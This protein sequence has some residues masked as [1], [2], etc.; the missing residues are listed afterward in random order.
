VVVLGG[1]SERALP[2]PDELRQLLHQPRTSLVLNLSAMSRRGEGRLR[3]EGAQRGGVRALDH[4][5]AALADPRR[6]RTTSAP[7][8]GPPS[9]TCCRGGAESLC[10]IT[11]AVTDLAPDVRVLPN[12][13]A[14]TELEASRRPCAPP[15]AADGPHAVRRAAGAGEIV[16]RWLGPSPARG[17]PPREAPRAAPAPLC[18]STRRAS[19]R[20]TDLSTSETAGALNLRAANSC[21]SSSWP[22]ASTS[23]RGR[24][25]SSSTITRRGRG[26]KIKDEG[27]ATAL[28]EVEDAAGARRIAPPPPSRDPRALYRVS[29]TASA[30]RDLADFSRD[31]GRRTGAFVS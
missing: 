20:R 29:L 7:P 17:V 6:R 12:V 24:G 5:A 19:C 8:T 30:L 14:A 10:M 31:P 26:R 15:A 16:H 22:R 4:R 18:A 11:L 23:R 3:H 21:A 2:T 1:S 9:S 25:T 13:V 27:L 28:K